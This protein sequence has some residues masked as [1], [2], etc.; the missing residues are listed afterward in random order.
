[1]TTG[2]GVWSPCVHSQET[3]KVEGSGQAPCLLFIQ[4]RT[5][6]YD[7]VLSTLGIDF[8]ASINPVQVILHR[9]ARR[10]DPVKICS[11][12]FTRPLNTRVCA[13]CCT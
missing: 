5:L 11:E 12:V 6:A 3:E 8:L 9:H 10:L 1:M 2:E 13:T 4:S 7:T